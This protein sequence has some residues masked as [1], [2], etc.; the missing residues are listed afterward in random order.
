MNEKSLKH[1]I[2]YI[3]PYGGD[4]AAKHELT[5]LAADTFEI[6]EKVKK[7]AFL[8]GRSGRIKNWD[9]KTN[10]TQKRQTKEEDHNIWIKAP[11]ELLHVT[12]DKQLLSRNTE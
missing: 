3:H 8:T 7:W 1:I 4:R 5:M 10:K 2:V 6:A 11:Q 9:V 12:K